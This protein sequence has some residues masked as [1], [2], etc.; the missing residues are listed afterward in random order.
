MWCPKGTDLSINTSQVW[1]DAVDYYFG[2][3]PPNTVFVVP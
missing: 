3:Q 1:Q 2:G